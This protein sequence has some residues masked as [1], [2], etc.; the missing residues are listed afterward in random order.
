MTGPFHKSPL[1]ERP[2][3]I[4]MGTPGFAV[5][6]LKALIDHGHEVVCVV[7]QPDRPK[8][9]GK[10]LAASPVKDLAKENG[11]EVLQPE[12]ASEE[13]FC[14]LIKQREPDLIIV[15][16]FG[17]ILRKRLLDIPKWGVINIHASLLPKY[18]GA[19]PI[20]RAILNNE[21]KTGLTIMRMDEGLDTGPILFQEEVPILENETAGHLNDRLAEGAGDLM[22]RFLEHM[23]RNP[24]TEKLQDDAAATYASKIE[25]SL[26]RINWNESAVRISALIRALDPRPGAYAVLENQEVKFFCSRVLDSTGKEGVPG[27]VVGHRGGEL[28]VE[29]GEG[30]VGIGEIQYPGKKRLPADDFLRGYDLPEGTELGK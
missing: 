3:V 28:V 1:P 29:T 16:A 25:K 23:A 30:R 12:R 24:I 2:R 26:A 20:Q 22:V 14:E 11:I 4:F 7:T 15:V 19:A 21:T 10:K 9:R 18:R 13:G 5:P 6:T 17:Q 8:G 27:T